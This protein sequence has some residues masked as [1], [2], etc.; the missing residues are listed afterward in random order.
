[1]Q[2]YDFIII[3]AGS[4]GCVLANRLS[5]DSRNRV[6][7]LEAGGR[8]NSL[9]V[10][11]P[12]GVSTLLGSRNRHNW[13]FVAEAAPEL[14]DRQ[15]HL[16]RGKGLGGSSSI[17][18]MLYVRG[19]RADYDRWGQMGLRGW[20]YEDVLPYFRRSE[21][22]ADGG[23]EFHGAGGL[24]HV[25]RPKQLGELQA[26][27][28]AAAAQAGHKPNTDF[29]GAEQEGF[30]TYQIN[31]LKGRRSGALAAFLKPALKRP[32]LSTITEA[33][34]TRI[35]IE[36]G[37]ATG[38]EYRIGSD[39]TLHRAGSQREVILSAGAFQSPH[40]LQL[41]GIGDADDLAAL[42]IQTVQNLPGVGRNL[43]DHLDIPVCFTC[44][45][46][47]SLYSQIKGFRRNLIGLRYLLT[48]G[49]LGASTGLEVGGFVRSREGLIAPDIQ[50]QFV[51]GVAWQHK[52]LPVE[53]YTA[54]IVLLH[55]ESRG[56][57]TLAS[58]NPLDDPKIDLGLLTKP[59]DL[60]TLRAGIAIARK[61]AA[62]PAL[63]PYTSGEFEPGSNIRT[64][65]E[66]DRWLRNSAQTIFHPVG[67][68]RMGRAED[69]NAVVDE[70]LRVRG[71]TGLR[72]VDASIMPEIVS[73]NTNAPTIMI[74]E[75]AADMILGK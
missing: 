61:L 44:P 53:G 16:A 18:G 19:N 32:N 41:S 35:L 13:N 33:R 73:G 51:H 60:A 10:S 21:D 55:P 66:L 48:H 64:D 72:V 30:G 36:A 45:K 71:I 74:A 47:V 49:G 7:L 52:L 54:D 27:A 1:M 59:N 9:M 8:N 14:S 63:A 75:K 3:G 23:D 15:L 58:A 2:N 11:M 50:I 57:V 65:A 68:C 26:A 4:A 70:T 43:Q 37:R 46:P 56:S 62:Q 29:N 5:A 67:T 39:P 24:W 69:P 40:L 42:G 17:N 25:A 34:V 31:V 20:S 22:F 28:I 38:V 6:L 12:A